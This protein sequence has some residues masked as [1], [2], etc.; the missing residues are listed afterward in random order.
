MTCQGANCG[1][2]DRFVPR[3]IVDTLKGPIEE[4]TLLEKADRKVEN[5]ITDVSSRSTLRR[6]PA[7]PP[8]ESISSTQKDKQKIKAV[9]FLLN[10]SFGS[11]L[12]LIS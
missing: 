2:G 7:L 6:R 10:P 3:S 11:L 1:N 9:F 5:A 8:S 12:A 4:K